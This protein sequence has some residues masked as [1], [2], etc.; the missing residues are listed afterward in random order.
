MCKVKPLYMYMKFDTFS[1]HIFLHKCF[2]TGHK[3]YIHIMHMYM[4]ILAK[5]VSQN[6]A[7]ETKKKLNCLVIRFLRGW[8][9]SFERNSFLK[10]DNTK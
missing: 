3:F 8:C 7:W 4:Y 10:K 2:L 9:F 1:I 5:R 6:I